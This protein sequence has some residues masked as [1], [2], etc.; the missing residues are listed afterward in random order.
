ML[1]V[2]LGAFLPLPLIQICRDYSQ[3]FDFEGTLVME[4]DTQDLVLINK[5]TAE[6]KTFAYDYKE[7]WGT[8][9]FRLSVQ[10]KRGRWFGRARLRTLD[11]DLGHAEVGQEFFIRQANGTW[12]KFSPHRCLQ[13][14]LLDNLHVFC[15]TEFTNEALQLLV[16]SKGSEHRELGGFLSSVPQFFNNKLLFALNDGNIV[17]VFFYHYSGNRMQPLLTLDFF[18]EWIYPTFTAIRLCV[19][20][21]VSFMGFSRKRVFYW[22]EGRIQWCLQSP[23]PVLRHVFTVAQTR[24]G[25]WLCQTQDT[26][27]WVLE[28]SGNETLACHLWRQHSEEII[29]LHNG[30]VA[31][32]GRTCATNH[33]LKSY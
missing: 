27:V 19:I 30:D 12:Q 4:Y 33:S 7:W 9:V 6:V 29:Q 13:A 26:G 5:A 15:Y 14:G 3:F 11:L 23:N 25:M 24:D 31:R 16:Y 20:T 8:I 10:L 17:T 1:H 32:L 21:S 18:G 22:T 28:K 2:W